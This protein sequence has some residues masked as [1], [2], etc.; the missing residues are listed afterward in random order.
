MAHSNPE[1]RNA[2]IVAEGD[3]V[4]RQLV[5]VWAPSSPASEAYRTLRTSLL[6]TLVDDPPKVIVVTSPG[7]G[8]GKSTVCANLG[9]ALAQASKKTLV[10]DCDFRKPVMQSI[11]GLS[12][13]QGVVNVLVEGHNLEQVCQEPLPE[14]PL[15]VVTVGPLPPNPAELL[16]SRRLSEFLSDAREKFDYVLVDSPPTGL[17]SD[18]AILAAQADGVLITLDA[19]RTRKGDLRKAMR[20][21]HAVGTTVLG[22]VV[23]K[24]KAG[25]GDGYGY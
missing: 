8:E 10:V 22:T 11:F 12:S 9:V 13:V 25:R 20:S 24:T 15:K 21:L 19:Q 7:T 23:N 2:G 14:L 16:G 18:P 17:V 1:K 4:A 6:Y 3:G 5:T